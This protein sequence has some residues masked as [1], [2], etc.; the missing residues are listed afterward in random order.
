MMSPDD[1]RPYL[2]ELERFAD[3]QMAPAEQE[4]FE[5]RLRQD[6]ALRRAHAAYEQLTGDLRWVAGHQTL[7]HRLQ[8]L[9]KRL[10]QRQEALTRM[11]RRQRRSQIRWGVVAASV[12][13][14]ALLAWALLRPAGSNVSAWERY[15][16]PD[17][18]LSATPALLGRPLLA[19]AMEQYQT[20]HYQAA[21]R[22][23]RRIPTDNVGRDTLL[24]YNGIFLLSM[25]EANAARSFLRRVT[26]QPGSALTGKANYHM[27]MAQWKAKQ[28]PEAR[29][30]LEL[31]AADASNPYR[32]PAQR[33][34]A[35]KAFSQE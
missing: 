30:T 31:V 22:T 16:Q 28:L 35:D 25:G 32:M 26:L 1:L 13:L 34:L 2:E 3:G 5:A 21:L 11:R 19:E 15:Y 23:L 4:A 7:A 9:D 24:Y 10:D 18:G 14:L 20:G 17:D 6:E 27:G 33:V 8:S 12:V 29:A